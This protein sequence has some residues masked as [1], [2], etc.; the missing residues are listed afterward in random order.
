[1]KMKMGAS[2]PIFETVSLITFVF[3]Q[4][5]ATA[6]TSTRPSHFK[7]ESGATY[8][9]VS[10][11]MDTSCAAPSTRLPH[12]S[13]TCH[14]SWAGHALAIFEG[15]GQIRAEIRYVLPDST[16]IASLP[17]RPCAREGTSLPARCC[18]TTWCRRQPWKAYS[19]YIYVYYCGW[20]ALV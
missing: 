17:F 6:S 8:Q 3:P 1:M 13:P 10:P 20:R 12:A 18:W 14:P 11:A 15:E 5:V 9:L 2:P 16:V 4:A 7:V 19:I